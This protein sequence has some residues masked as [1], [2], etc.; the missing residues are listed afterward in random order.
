MIVGHVIVHYIVVEVAGGST[1]V[2]TYSLTV[3]T[4]TYLQYISMV[5]GIHYHLLR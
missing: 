4:T 3:S 5:R 2:Q 1:D